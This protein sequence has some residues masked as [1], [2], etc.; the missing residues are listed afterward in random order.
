VSHGWGSLIYGL[1]VTV[2]LLLTPFRRLRWFAA[3]IVIASVYAQ[4]A[5]LHAFSSVWCYLTAMLSAL[6]LWVVDEPAAEAGAVAV[7]TTSST[8]RT[9]DMPQ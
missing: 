7:Q 6:L 3:A 9:I 2:P 8:P 4:V 1:I 5:Y